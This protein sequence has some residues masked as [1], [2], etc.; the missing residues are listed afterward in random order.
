M[1]PFFLHNKLRGLENSLMDPYDDPEFTHYLMNRISDF[2]YENHKRMFE[3]CEGLI[4]L[5]QVTD[6]FGSQTGS[7]IS[8]DTFREFYKPYFKSFND[9][10]KSFGIKVF[11]HDD[12]SMRP[13]LPDLVELG[14]DILNTIQ[15][16]CPGM[17]MKELKS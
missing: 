4:D 10:A 8:L 7:M 15:H 12:G 9:L 1:A 13:L 6:D 5:T 16:N 11:H 14:I 2:M 17:D 3:A